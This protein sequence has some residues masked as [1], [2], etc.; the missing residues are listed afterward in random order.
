MDQ[1]KENFN[2]FLDTEKLVFSSALEEKNLHKA[3]LA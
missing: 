1:V 3:T 2:F